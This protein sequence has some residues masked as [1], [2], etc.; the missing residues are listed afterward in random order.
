MPCTGT[1]V[2]KELSLGHANPKKAAPKGRGTLA[3]PPAPP[4]FDLLGS[5]TEELQARA[6][7]HLSPVSLGSHMNACDSSDAMS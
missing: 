1:R 5:T 3:H 2:Y 4:S 6:R 7:V